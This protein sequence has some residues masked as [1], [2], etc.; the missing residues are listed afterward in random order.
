MSSLAAF[1]V[2]GSCPVRAAALLLC[3]WISVNLFLGAALPARLQHHVVGRAAVAH[4]SHHL[5]GV[6]AAGAHA[7]AVRIS[8]S[9]ACAVAAVVRAGDGHWA[10]AAAAL[11]L[12]G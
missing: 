6:R 8:H 11:G 5:G 3:G 9:C 2:D 7:G 1:A 10:V 4:S 12:A